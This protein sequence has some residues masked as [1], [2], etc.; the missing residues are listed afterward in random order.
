MQTTA[1]FDGLGRPMETVAKKASPLQKDVVSAVRYDEYGREQYKYF[2]FV[3]TANDGNF[4]LDPF[5]QQISFYNTYL[6]GQTG[7]TYTGPNNDLNWGYAQTVFETSP[8]NRVEKSLAPGASWVGGNR[9]IG[10]AYE[11]NDAN[12]VRLWT[13]SGTGLQVPV[14]TVWYSAN[15]LY[16][17][18]TTD[19]NG[20]R[21]VEYKD[22]EGKVILKK[23]EIKYN[24]AA[25]ITSH[26]DWLCT[27]YIYDDLNN[28]RFVIPPKA[29]E[30]LLSTW[31]FGTTNF[32]SSDIAKELCFYYEYDERSRMIMKKVP[33][34]GE[35]YMVYDSRDRLVM[36]QDANMRSSN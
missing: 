35:V 17:T 32:N 23:V 29:V 25:T 18:I 31:S 2:P 4:K 22:K 13:I 3:S 16:R 11:L 14:S 9:G 34:A 12:E 36:T 6:S 20:K 33:G 30:A 5:Q 1:Y 28:L 15:E 8:L 7:E 10:M 26:T 19:E 24:G 21:V 27:Y